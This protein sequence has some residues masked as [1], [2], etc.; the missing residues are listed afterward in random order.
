[1]TSRDRRAISL[2]AAVVLPVLFVMWGVRPYLRGVRELGREI[3]TQRDLVGPERALLVARPGL[4]SA[5]A[6]LR[7]SLPRMDARLFPGADELGASAA[8]ASYVSDRARQHGVLV[9]QA[10][11]R[12]ASAGPG[13]LAAIE[14]S[15][16][17]T[18]DL[19]GILEWLDAL[20]RGPRFVEVSRL[21]IQRTGGGS[22]QD[23]DRETLAVRVI[24]RGYCAGVLDPRLKPGVG[25]EVRP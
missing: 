16:G 10:E 1:M 12:P 20:E 5:L 24:V 11:T 22:Q 25:E 6:A 7:A 8:L 23:A 4:D 14:V 3:A 2:G 13:S 9:Q 18:G 19:Q 21:G 17:A 15:L